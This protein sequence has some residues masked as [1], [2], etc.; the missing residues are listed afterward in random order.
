MIKLFRQIRQNLLA[1]G[2]TTKYFKY[3]IGEIILVVIGILIALQLNIQKEAAKERKV[4]EQLLMG[5]K[6]DLQLEVERIDFLQSY[7][8]EV[9][10]GIQT[11]LLN[12]QGKESNTNE[13]LGQ[14]FLNTFEFRKFSKFNTNYQTLYRSSL[15]QEIAD[16]Q[17]SEDII[18]Y[19][20]TQFL[21]WSLEIYQQ[22]AS[23]FNFNDATQFNP[24][25]KLKRNVNYD[26]I[27]NYR[28]DVGSDYRTN[29]KE[30]INEP[31]VLNFL[32]DLLH[33]SELVFKNLENYKEANLT[34][35]NRIQK[36][37]NQ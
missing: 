35:S 5:V 27:P 13:E 25:D 4:T 28:L 12:F 18:T 11:I 15:L 19:Y 29:F 24:P 30:F 33:Q 8:G 3:A 21:E 23:A 1:E 16:K 10:D 2:K 7:Y 17:L 14:Y 37:L 6:A 20:S 22:K 9:T 34:L 26:F 32:V 31:Q 36:Y